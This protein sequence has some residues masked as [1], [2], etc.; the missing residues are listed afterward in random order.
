MEFS[1]TLKNLRESREI[2]QEELAKKLRVSRPTIAGY[3]TKH[4][5]PDFHKLLLLSEFFEVSVDYLLTGKEAP[6]DFSSKA[7]VTTEK[8]LD[9]KVMSGYKK[10]NYEHKNDVLKYIQLLQF[11]EDNTK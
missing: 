9:R 1:K 2:T 6:E 11:K 10:L 8:S 4:R 5:E 3:E 7:P